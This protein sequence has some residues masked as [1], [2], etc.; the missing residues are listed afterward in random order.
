MWGLSNLIGARELGQF[1]GA[2]AGINNAVRIASTVILALAGTMALLYAMYV[3][4]KFAKA[5][6]DAQRKEAKMKL[7]YSLVGVLSIAILVLL[8]NTVFQSFTTVNVSG[9]NIDAV[10]GAT[11][12]LVH[13]NHFVNAIIM[14]LTTAAVVFAVWL[15]WQLMKAED[16]AKRKQA[17]AQLLYT[18]IGVIAII[19]VNLVITAVLDQLI[20]SGL[21]NTLP[22]T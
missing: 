9:G 22:G 2:T 19:L 13:V 17:K 15:G 14:V 3:G 20:R 6:D 16:D 4:W 21:K 5:Q 12:T 8:F 18:L 11:A 10:P 1:A 7:V